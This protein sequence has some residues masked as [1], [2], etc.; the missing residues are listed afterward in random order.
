[1][2][3]M[4]LFML[5]LTLSASTIA[6]VSIASNVSLLVPTDQ[7]QGIRLNSD[8]SSIEP[9]GDPVGGGGG[10]PGSKN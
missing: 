9:N 7:V 5:L 6:T 1:M 3:G 8:F 10:G 2:K 4:I